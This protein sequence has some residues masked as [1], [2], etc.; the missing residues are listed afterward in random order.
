MQHNQIYDAK[1]TLWDQVRL[2]GD[3]M[4]F[5]R[6][7]GDISPVTLRSSDI[8]EC[9]LGCTIT[10]IHLVNIPPQYRGNK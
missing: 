2:S 6:V 7:A 10:S 5:I 3:R 4:L 8:L 9:Q 1:V